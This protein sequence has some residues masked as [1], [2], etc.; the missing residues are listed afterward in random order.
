MDSITYEWNPS[1][2]HEDKTEKEQNK[3]N[4]RTFVGL[5]TDTYENLRKRYEPEQAK[6]MT[7]GIMSVFMP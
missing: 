5:I 3:E 1:Q 6:E 2:V 7:I 4:M